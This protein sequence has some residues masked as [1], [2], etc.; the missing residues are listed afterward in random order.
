L[1]H[2]LRISNKSQTTEFNSMFT[3]MR[4]HTRDE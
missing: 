4:I 3:Y 2:F 1:I